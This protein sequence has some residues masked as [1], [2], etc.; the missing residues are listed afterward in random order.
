MPFEDREQRVRD[1]REAWVDAPRTVRPGD[2]ISRAVEQLLAQP[3]SRMVYVVDAA[4]KLVGVVSWRSVLKATNARMGARQPGIVSLVQ[5]F[6]NLMPERVE[7]L[8]RRPAPLTEDMTVEQAL[9]LMDETH[10]NDLPV[11]D[12]EGRLVGELNGMH[13]MRLAL[14]VFRRGEEALERARGGAADVG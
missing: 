14:D 10:Q 2:P 7:D 13:I 3:S 11:V 1:L 6:R 12:A 4:N 5:L 8:M 9:L